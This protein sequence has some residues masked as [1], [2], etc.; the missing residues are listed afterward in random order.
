MRYFLLLV[1]VWVVTGCSATGSDFKTTAT[2]GGKGVVHVY[3]PTNWRATWGDAPNISVDG[4]RVGS[5]KNA[6]FLTFQLPPGRHEVEVR[7]PLMQWFGG[8]K[9]KVNV[10]PGGKY[11]LR[12]GLELDD[13]VFGANGPLPISS[14]HI[15]QVPARK[16]LAEIKK[17]K[18][19]Q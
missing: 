16:A 12:V 10:A 8:R 2:S 7:V 18:S 14:F 17:T 1:V 5:L 3:R 4:R 13:I 6:G 11:Y 15:Q 9:A 19:S